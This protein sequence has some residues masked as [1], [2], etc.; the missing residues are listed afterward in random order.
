MRPP[1]LNVDPGTPGAEDIPGEFLCF[2]G[3]GLKTT[4]TRVG[5]NLPGAPETAPKTAPDG[6][7]GGRAL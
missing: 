4:D 1:V 7:R 5:T 6:A 2:Y 3:I